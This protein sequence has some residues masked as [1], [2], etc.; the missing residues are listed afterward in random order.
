MKTKKWFGGALVLSAALS[1]AMAG[2]AWAQ[3]QERGYGSG[4][5]SYGS[6]P[7]SGYGSQKDKKQ[8]PPSK[9]ESQ[10]SMGVCTPNPAP[11][12]KHLNLPPAVLPTRRRPSSWTNC[13]SSVLYFANSLSPSPLEGRGSG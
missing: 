4:S 11:A 12:L 2:G 3:S 6:E 7:E 10:G 13:Q 1:L 8:T 9:S 5:G